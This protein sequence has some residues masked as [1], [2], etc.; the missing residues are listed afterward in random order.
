[1]SDLGARGGIHLEFPISNFFEVRQLS[2]HVRRKWEEANAIHRE[3]SEE[4]IEACRPHSSAIDK[5]LVPSP[6]Q[7]YA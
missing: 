6:L 7:R 2:S 3:G 1:M 4:L 5:T